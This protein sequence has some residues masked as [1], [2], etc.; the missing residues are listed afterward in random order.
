MK[1]FNIRYLPVFDRKT[2]RGIISADDIL[3]EAVY[4]QE[5]IFDEE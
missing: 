1:P 2:F 3:A 5:R 4:L